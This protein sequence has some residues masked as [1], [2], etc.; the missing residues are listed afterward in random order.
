MLGTFYRAPAPGE[1]MEVA[2]NVVEGDLFLFLFFAIGLVT[3]VACPVIYTVWGRRRTL[4]TL[5]L[6]PGE[7]RSLG[8]AVRI[9]ELSF[10]GWP[11][12]WVSLDEAANG[13]GA[14]WTA[15]AGACGIADRAAGRAVPS[16]PAG[17]ARRSHRPDRQC[18]GR[19]DAAKG[20]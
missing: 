9:D 6:S 3:G 17:S 11:D 4:A 1:D 2:F 12:A 16:T 15:V 19:S 20:D 7:A 5:G 14:F 8:L 13:V 18:R 10:G